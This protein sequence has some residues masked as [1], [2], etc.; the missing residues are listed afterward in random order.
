[1]GCPCVE[2]GLGSAFLRCKIFLVVGYQKLLNGWMTK[3]DACPAN[4]KGYEAPRKE[5]RCYE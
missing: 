1:M 5:V 2:P 3:G 4:N